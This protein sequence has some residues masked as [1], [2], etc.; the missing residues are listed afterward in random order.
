MMMMVTLKLAML[1]ILLP[2][3]KSDANIENG[4]TC[5]ETENENSGDIWN[6]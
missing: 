4:D 5:D 3:C 6:A 1:Y 2:L